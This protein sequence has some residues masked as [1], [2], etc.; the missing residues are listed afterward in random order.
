MFGARQEAQSKTGKRQIDPRTLFDLVYVLAQHPSG[1]RRWSVMRAI[2]T[3]RI[4]TNRIIPHRIEDEVERVFRS[5]CNDF[6][7]KAKNKT[8]EIPLF[9]LQKEKPGEVWAVYPARV[10]MVLNETPKF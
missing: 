7:S 10:R 2:R 8:A 9:Y 4:R 1:L 6:Q 3:E 5:R